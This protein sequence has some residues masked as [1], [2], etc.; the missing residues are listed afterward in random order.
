M[1]LAVCLKCRTP[2]FGAYITCKKCGF[3]PPSQAERDA[4]I[5]YSDHFLSL[6]DLCQLAGLSV[7]EF[8]EKA[9]DGPKAN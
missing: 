1:T 9:L 2:K 8:V 5:G 4:S 7:E 6:D 3:A